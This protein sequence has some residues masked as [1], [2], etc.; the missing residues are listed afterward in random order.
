MIRKIRLW[1]RLVS[2]S[3][4]EEFGHK[5]VETKATTETAPPAEILATLFDDVRDEPRDVPSMPLSE[6]VRIQEWNTFLEEARRIKDEK[7]FI[8]PTPES[9]Q[10]FTAELVFMRLLAENNLWH[11]I[12]DAWVT[13]L[14]PTGHLVRFQ[15]DVSYAFVLKAYVNVTLCGQAE[16]VAINM[17]RKA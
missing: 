15:R 3:I 7:H 9:E 8:G 5:E 10:V 2:G 1:D 6:K 17:W 4:I 13:G 11:Q 14:L 12:G 16:K